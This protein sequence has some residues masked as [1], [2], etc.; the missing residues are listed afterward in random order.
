VTATGK[1]GHKAKL[2]SPSWALLAVSSP[3]AATRDRPSL[4]RRRVRVG[5]RQRRRPSTMSGAA[6]TPEAARSLITVTIVSASTPMP[7]PSSS[8]A[9]TRATEPGCCAASHRRSAATERLRDLLEQGLQ[10]SE[11][12][13][14]GSCG[15]W[16]RL[17]RPLRGSTGHFLRSACHAA[18]LGGG[19]MTDTRVQPPPSRRIVRQAKQEGTKT[20]GPWRGL[21]RH[22]GGLGASSAASS[23]SR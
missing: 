18:E 21:D 15:R 1:V 19:A 5:P 10:R 9:P 2:R 17:G 23:P 20:P 22:C 16:P 11:S 14:A 7:R 6:R 12:A 8:P 13:D 3:A 4:V